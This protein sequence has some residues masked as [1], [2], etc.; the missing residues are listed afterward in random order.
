MNKILRKWGIRQGRKLAGEAASPAT[1][2]ST[3]KRAQIEKDQENDD[4]EAPDSGQND[5]EETPSK[6]AKITKK[7]GNADADD[8]E[9]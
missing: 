2:K 4:V 1:P 9:K 8:N 6:K 7:V 5:T 3:I